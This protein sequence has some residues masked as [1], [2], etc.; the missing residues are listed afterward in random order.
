MSDRYAS[1]QGAALL[2]PEMPKTP[3]H[4]PGLHLEDVDQAA[5][6]EYGTPSPEERVVNALCEAATA[7]GNI[8]T[9]IGHLSPFYQH[10]MDPEAQRLFQSLNALQ[11]DVQALPTDIDAAIAVVS[12]W[13]RE[14][15]RRA[16]GSRY[17]RGQMLVGL[18]E[19][20]SVV[21]EYGREAQP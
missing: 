14:H 19:L 9:L 4:T 20:R 6:E 1:S 18:A 16:D 13:L 3:T 7:L 11:N 21:A 12:R 5:A 17:S 2:I 10:R 15:E 8:R